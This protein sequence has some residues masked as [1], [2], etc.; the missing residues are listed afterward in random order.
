MGGPTVPFPAWKPTCWGKMPS[1]GSQNGPK[2]GTVAAARQVGEHP[3]AEK[4][5]AWWLEVL[6]GQAGRDHPIYGSRIRAALKKDTLVVDGLLESAKACDELRREI[7]SLEGDGVKHLRFHV[8][9]DGPPGEKGLLRQ[10][11]LAFFANDEQAEMARRYLEGHPD[12][13]PLDARI[14]RS[15]SDAAAFADMPAA[16]ERQLSRGF[17]HADAVLLIDVDEV[18]AF[19]ANELLA[20]S[21]S[22][23]VL[24]LPPEIY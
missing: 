3:L 6:S 14:E 10:R 18:E 9:V 8:K 23:E 12:V 16:W 20:E 13:E 4:V 1:E 11:I 19:R 24:V 22:T 5:T 15:S 21:G 17:K 2:G 7:S